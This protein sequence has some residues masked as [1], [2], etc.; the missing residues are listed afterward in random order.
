M[1]EPESESSDEYRRDSCG[2]DC[3]LLDGADRAAARAHEGQRCSAVGAGRL[4]IAHLA[5]PV[6]YGRRRPM[7]ATRPT[8]ERFPPVGRLGV[9]QPLAIVVN[10]DHATESVHQKLPSAT[11]AVITIVVRIMGGAARQPLDCEEMPDGSAART[12]RSPQAPPRVRRRLR[13]LDAPS[14]RGAGTDTNRVRQQPRKQFQ[15][16]SWRQHQM[17]PCRE[18]ETANVFDDERQIVQSPAT[19]ALQ[20]EIRSA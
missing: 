20:N 11:H 12:W 16:R 4:L 8:C 17:C 18:S 19:R 14:R 10:R 15:H 13:S 9:L 5:T 1:T 3:D 6:D 2:L 7:R